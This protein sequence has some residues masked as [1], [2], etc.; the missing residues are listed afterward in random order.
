MLMSCRVK[1]R[2]MQHFQAL[3]TAQQLGQAGS[4]MDSSLLQ[5]THQFR[6]A[7]G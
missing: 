5:E 1:S 2:I 3:P 7:W 6:N 4:C